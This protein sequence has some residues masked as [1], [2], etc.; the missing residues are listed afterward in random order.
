MF[1]TNKYTHEKISKCYDLDCSLGEFSENFI[2]STFADMC[3]L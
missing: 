3:T 1:I 2:E